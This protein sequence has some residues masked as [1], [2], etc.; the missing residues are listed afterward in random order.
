MG[1]LDKEIKQLY[2]R[3]ARTRYEFL[4]NEVQSC[5]TALDMAEFQLSTTNRAGAESEAAYVT[6]GVA[7]LHRF[8]PLASTDHQLEIG[9]K[10]AEIEAALV[11]LKARLYPDVE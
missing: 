10:L 4:K 8:L 2:E 9:R 11:S 6:K 5:R 3:T 7:V 1:N